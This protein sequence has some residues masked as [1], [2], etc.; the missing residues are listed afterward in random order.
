MSHPMLEKVARAIAKI[1]HN[2]RVAE[3]GF[4]ANPD[5]GSFHYRDMARA[6]IQAL[7]EPDE[8]MLSAGVMGYDDNSPYACEGYFDAEDAAA[9]LRAMLKPLLGDEGAL[10]Q[11]EENPRQ[12]V[13]GVYGPD[14]HATGF[15]AK[16]VG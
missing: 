13:P 2:G 3:E 4:W 5:T 12:P 14:Q 10:P 7:M 15:V 11:S 1:D 6:A 8:G 16:E 9:V